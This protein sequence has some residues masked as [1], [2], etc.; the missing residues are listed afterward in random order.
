MIVN[1]EHA[2]DEWSPQK[3]KLRVPR[4]SVVNDF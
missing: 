3:T 4:A 1:G 2:G